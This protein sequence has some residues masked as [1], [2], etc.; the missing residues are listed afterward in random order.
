MAINCFDLG[1]VSENEQQQQNMQRKGNENIN[2]KVVQI[3]NQNKGDVLI[4]K[5]QNT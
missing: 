3:Q 2:N 1:L 5:H 4:P